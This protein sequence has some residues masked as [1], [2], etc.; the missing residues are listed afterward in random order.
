MHA[1]EVRKFNNHE[2]TPDN[3]TKQC[4]LYIKTEYYDCTG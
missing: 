1:L 3:M 4:L 2:M